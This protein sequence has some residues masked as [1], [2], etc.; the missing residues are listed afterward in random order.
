MFSQL[1]TDYIDLDL[2]RSGNPDVVILSRAKVEEIHLRSRGRCIKITIAPARR[3]M[4]TIY[5]AFESMVY[6][7]IS[8]QHT[9][10]LKTFFCKFAICFR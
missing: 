6:K 2:D 5:L 3:P 7:I 4:Q 1:H 10:V 8:L 9:N